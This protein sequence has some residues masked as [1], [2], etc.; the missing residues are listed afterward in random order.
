[1]FYRI[2]MKAS[3]EAAAE[4][5]ARWQ[6]AGFGDALV[7]TLEAVERE[8]EY[9]QNAGEPLSSL[10]QAQS[11][12]AFEAQYPGRARGR[13][14]LVLRSDDPP[15]VFLKS[16]DQVRLIREMAPM[17][18]SISGLEA[19]EQ[20]MELRGPEAEASALA[21]RN[22]GLSWTSLPGERSA[23]YAAARESHALAFWGA[24]SAYRDEPSADAW[25]KLEQQYLPISVVSPGIEA[26]VHSAPGLV[27]TVGD[28]VQSA[29][30]PVA[31]ELLERQ[32]AAYAEKL[33]GLSVTQS[34]DLDN[35]ELSL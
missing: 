17:F 3:P 18:E 22:D 19:A 12:D 5:N 29:G 28:L 33:E 30:Q 6:A 2:V 7:S 34:K 4:I 11:I 9:L 13:G 23:I 14:E 32:L 21:V 25:A 8:M 26:M 16:R 15:S 31:P 10:P 35:S 20:I 24:Y 27:R 1:M